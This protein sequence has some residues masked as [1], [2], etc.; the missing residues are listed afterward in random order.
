MKGSEQN[1]DRHESER[2]DST[3]TT[4]FDDDD[5]F[6]GFNPPARPATPAGTSLDI[7][8]ML[9]V[10]GHPG[11]PPARPG[12]A[13]YTPPP[14][15]SHPIEKIVYK[16]A[17]A[18]KRWYRQCTTCFGQTPLVKAQL[19]TEEMAAA[20]EYDHDGAQRHWQERHQAQQAEA[21]ATQAQHGQ[22][23]WAWYNAYLRSEEW[24]D[25]R[26]KVFRRAG[27]MCEGCQDVPANQVHHL[28]YEHVGYERLWE[29]VAIC[30]TCHEF[31]TNSRRRA[32]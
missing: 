23:W 29:L 24:A 11:P 26:R 19:S 28:S 25:R 4:S 15:C 10:T 30:T 3:V 9:G 31:V 18:G 14:E 2:N 32:T 16:Q 7:N 1:A 12:L 27:N 6:A 22:K 17:G 5:L 13:V 21:E 8:K 20:T